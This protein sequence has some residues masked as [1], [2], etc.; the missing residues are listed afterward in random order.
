MHRLK[1]SGVSTSDGSHGY[2]WKSIW[3]LKVPSKIKLFVWKA[4]NEHLPTS[5]N[6][7]KRGLD[8][9]PWMLYLPF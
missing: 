5:Q 1:C 7:N 8:V 6:L 3:D 9:V 4:V 2:N